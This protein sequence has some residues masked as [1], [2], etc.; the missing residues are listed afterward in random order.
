M[1]K[2]TLKALKY[3]ILHSDH[4]RTMLT[5]LLTSAEPLVLQRGL[6]E[7]ESRNPIENNN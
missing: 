4:K 7:G 2:I 3:R 1:L 5:L 6:G